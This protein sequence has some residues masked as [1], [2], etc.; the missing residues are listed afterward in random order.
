MG[1]ATDAVLP[2]FGCFDCLLAELQRILDFS[3]QSLFWDLGLFMQSI[4]SEYLVG[5]KS[6]NPLMHFSGWLVSSV[7][8]S[9]QRL[10]DGWLT[11][12]WVTKI[13]SS[14][15]IFCFSHESSKPC[16]R[17]VLKCPPFP[18]LIIFKITGV[19]K[20]RGHFLPMPQ[21]GFLWDSLLLK[22]FQKTNDCN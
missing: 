11:W 17:W 21:Q 20:G 3:P 22:H 16:S 5:I 14:L 15:S 4:N 10:E 9:C 18:H 1:I 7:W 13:L 2:Q 12:K 8:V 6:F 19:E